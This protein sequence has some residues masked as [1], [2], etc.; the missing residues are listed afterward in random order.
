MAKK[1]EILMNRISISSAVARIAHE[2]LD[3]KTDVDELVIIG[4]QR[5]GVYLAKRIA[6]N[7]YK[8]REKSVN[9]GILDITLYRD[10]LSIL[11][12]HPIINGTDIGFVV[13]NKNVVIVDDVLFTGRTIRAAIDAI[14]DIGRPKTIWVAVLIDRGHKELPIKANFVGKNVCTSKDEIVNVYL[15]EIDGKEFVDKF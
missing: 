6:D 13:D 7:I 10:D 3:K 4:I 1:T 14:I 11:S 2:I 5:R 9:V 15:D 12:Q 8:F